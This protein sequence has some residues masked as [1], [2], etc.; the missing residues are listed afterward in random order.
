MSVFSN[1][2]IFTPLA[3]RSPLS[4][5]GLLYPRGAEDL[6]RSL[7]VDGAGMDVEH[8]GV[9]AGHVEAEAATN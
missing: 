8:L 2:G 5:H 6:V 1:P 7:E 4:E 9:H 3:G